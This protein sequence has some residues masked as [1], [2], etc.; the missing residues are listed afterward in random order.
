M[1]T[2]VGHI[3]PSP[4]MVQHLPSQT[5]NGQLT[6]RECVEFCTALP[7]ERDPEAPDSI[8]LHSLQCITIAVNDL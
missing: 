4:A 3:L 8:T 6:V 1:E 2:S 7:L 5:L